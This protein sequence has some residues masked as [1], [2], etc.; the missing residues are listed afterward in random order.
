MSEVEAEA[1]TSGPPAPVFVALLGSYALAGMLLFCGAI[2]FLVWKSVGDQVGIGS[3]ILGFLV[4]GATYYAWRGS[5]RG[6]DVLG[7]FAAVGAIGGG[8][9]M[10]VGPGSAFIVSLVIAALG[11]GTI[12]LLYLPEASK[13]YFGSSSA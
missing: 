1:P 11:A 6:R 2:G 13:R 9:Y 12:A 8:I 4:L 10:F 3:T 7:F 5:R